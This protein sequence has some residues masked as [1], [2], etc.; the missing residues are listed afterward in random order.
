[1]Q[2]LQPYPDLPSSPLPV[3]DPS[4]LSART[5]ETLCVYWGVKGCGLLRVQL[6][7]SSTHENQHYL[8]RSVN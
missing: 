4:L 2:K 1:M 8:R 3:Y 7:S 5:K 6:T